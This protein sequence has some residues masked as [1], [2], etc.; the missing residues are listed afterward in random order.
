MQAL[1]V[2]FSTSVDISFIYDGISDAVV[3]VAVRKSTE[4]NYVDLLV[5]DDDLILDGIGVPGEVGGRAS[6][7]QDIK[8]MIRETGLLV[9]LIGERSTTKVAVNMNRIEIKIENDLRIKP[10]T[11]RVIRTDIGTFFMTAKTIKYGDLEFYL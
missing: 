9:E 10:G 4:L 2:D 6:I 8:H 7:A 1:D 5:V 3:S 11:A